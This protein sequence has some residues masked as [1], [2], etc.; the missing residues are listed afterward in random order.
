MF[1]GTHKR[2]Q[3]EDRL[4]YMLIDGAGLPFYTDNENPYIDIRLYP[5]DNWAEVV[6]AYVRK[7]ADKES[8]MALRS[9]TGDARVK[10]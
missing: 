1:K 6:A 10:Q 2:F 7:G 5:S 8:M 9:R 4:K 3:G